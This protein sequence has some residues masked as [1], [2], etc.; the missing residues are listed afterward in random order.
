MENE[1]SFSNFLTNNENSL[2]FYKKGLSYRKT[3]SVS[4][5]DGVNE[6]ALRLRYRGGEPQQ[7]RLIK[8][9]RESLNRALYYSYQGAL[10]KKYYQDYLELMDGVREEQP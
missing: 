2:N 5:I 7:D 9:K 4:S 8:D 3:S 10:V 6:M 1:K